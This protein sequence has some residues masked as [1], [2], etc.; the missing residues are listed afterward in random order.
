MRNRKSIGEADQLALALHDCRATLDSGSASQFPVRRLMG[1][2]A[3]KEETVR[4]RR[5]AGLVEKLLLEES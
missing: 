2:K 4:W 1:Q 5:L 3:L